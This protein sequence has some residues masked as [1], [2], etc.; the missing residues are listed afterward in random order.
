MAGAV[1][2]FK[3]LANIDKNATEFVKCYS[4]V[5]ATPQITSPKADI[6]IFHAIENGLKTEGAKIVSKMLETIPPME[7]INSMLIPR[8]NF[9]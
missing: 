4:G 2:A 5:T 7:I 3:L 1:R 8:N 9:V 6:D